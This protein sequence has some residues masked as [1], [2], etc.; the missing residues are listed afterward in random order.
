MTQAAFLGLDV[1]GYPSSGLLK[2]PGYDLT[3]FNRTFAKTYTWVA[4]HGGQSGKPH[5]DTAT[6]AGNVIACVRQDDDLR[7]VCCGK[8]GA[9]NRQVVDPVRQAL[10][11]LTPLQA[12]ADALTVRPHHP[13]HPSRKDSL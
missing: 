13:C 12:V 4:E 10:G 6:G 7:A 3:V 1:M 11:G 2:S 8:A 9:E 5:A